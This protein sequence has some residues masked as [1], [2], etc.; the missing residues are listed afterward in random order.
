M[1]STNTMS[2]SRLSR[3]ATE[4]KISAGDLVQGVEQE[5]HRPVGLIVGELDEPLDRDPLGDPVWS[6]PA[7]SPA[8]TPAARPVRTAPAR[9]PRRPGGARPRPGGAPRR[10]RAVPTSG[11]TSTPRPAAESRAPRPPPPAVAGGGDGLLRGEEPR[12]RRHQPGQRG[13]VD[14]VGPPE[15]VDHFRDRVAADRMPL[16]V[17]QLQVAHHRA[18]RGWSAASP[19]GTRLQP[20]RITAAHVQRHAQSRVPTEFRRPPGPGTP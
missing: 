16:V 2:R 11:P 6:R 20:N 19:A 17:R 5:V 1:V 9:P 10:S 4:E 14:L 8:P 12:D 18:V 13:P 7:S 3:W 15:V